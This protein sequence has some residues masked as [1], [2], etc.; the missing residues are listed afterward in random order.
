MS[1]RI[2]LVLALIL[3]AIPLTAA[4]DRPPAEAAP[5]AVEESAAE[6]APET[7]TGPD[8]E[9]ALAGH[10]HAM[11]VVIDPETGRMR[12]PTE[13]EWQQHAFEHG[14]DRVFQDRDLRVTE[15][16]RGAVI[17]HLDERFQRSAVAVISADGTVTV[18]HDAILVAPAP[19][20]GEAE[21]PTEEGGSPDEPR[22]AETP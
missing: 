4:E 3:G 17:L 9:T 8:V 22:K 19:E 18:Q 15:G 1:L 12:P 5:E 2:L 6:P 7:A 13:D 20:T 10:T 11:Q 16:V 21:A 14:G